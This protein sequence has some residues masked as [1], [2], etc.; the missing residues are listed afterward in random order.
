M[1]GLTENLTTK[2]GIQVWYIQCNN[3]RE[4]DDFERVCKQK[5][6]E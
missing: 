5:G 2:Y 6:W 1:L 4:N 3:A